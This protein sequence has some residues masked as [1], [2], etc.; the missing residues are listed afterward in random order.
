MSGNDTPT[1]A[2]VTDYEA[3]PLPNPDQT[4][5]EEW[6]VHQ[7]RAF[8]W[9]EVR[10]AGV[11]GAVNQSAIADKFCCDKSRISR[12]MKQI[13]K[14]MAATDDTRAAATAA[15]VYEKAVEELMA[16]GEYMKAVR[17]TDSWM[18]WL[19][20]TGRQEK[21]AEKRELDILTAETET[22]A[23]TVVGPDGEPLGESEDEW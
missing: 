4:P 15:A 13:R 7:R 17:A 3:V 10:N 12:D 19:Q 20:D 14:A 1:N 18:E 2:D 8:L 16:D 21:A 11:P 9:Q 6:T 5:Y 22:E 23:M